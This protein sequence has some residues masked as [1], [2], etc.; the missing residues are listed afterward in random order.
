MTK[1]NHSFLD[2]HHEPKDQYPRSE[3]RRIPLSV[4]KKMMIAETEA[5]PTSPKIECI[6]CHVHL[7]QKFIVLCQGGW[8]KDDYNVCRLCYDK[9]KDISVD[10]RYK[11]M[12]S[13]P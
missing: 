7:I 1:Y 10:N 13:K 2:E 11:R 9:K 8:N 4:I 12:R 6:R 5:S 3:P